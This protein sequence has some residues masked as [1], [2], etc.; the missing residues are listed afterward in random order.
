MAHHP[1]QKDWPTRI[2][3]CLEE[4]VQQGEDRYATVTGRILKHGIQPSQKASKKNCEKKSGCQDEEEG[5]RVKSNGGDT[6]YD[7]QR[8][9]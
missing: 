8:A 3:R 9:V 6:L 4:K 2:V 7:Q 1:N 5:D